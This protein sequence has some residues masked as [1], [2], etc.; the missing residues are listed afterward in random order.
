MYY[1]DEGVQAL[2]Q[3]EEEMDTNTKAPQQVAPATELMDDFFG[4]DEARALG[5]EK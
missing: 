2:I 5:G 3:Q 4:A 1:H